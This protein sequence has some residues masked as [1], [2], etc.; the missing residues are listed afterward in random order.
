MSR[1]DRP[2]DGLRVKLVGD[3]SSVHGG[4][5]AVWR[6]IR[7]LTRQQGAT[8]V[9]EDAPYDVLIVNGEGS[10]HH[11]AP[12]YHRK[13]AVLADA[14]GRG[15]PA[16]LINT[17]WQDNPHD[18]DDVLQ[19]LEGVIVRESRSRDAIRAHGVEPVMRPDLSWFAPAR[20]PGRVRDFRGATVITD[21]YSP[22]FGH[23]ARPSAG[24]MSR[25]DYF[26]FPRFDWD[27]AIATLRTVRLLITGRQHAIYAC[28]RARTPFVAVKGNTHKIEG[29]IEMAGAD[30]P[31]LDRPGD[32]L[33][34]VEAM[35]ERRAEF[36]KLFD[37]LEAQSMDGAF[38]DLLSA[39]ALC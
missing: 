18:Q 24:R 23:F 28:C 4:C 38:P 33:E 37:W 3:H 30:I 11:G 35:L 19:V 16:W 12:S 25:M 29:L 10:M 9:G 27:G 39:R 22:D 32:A 2:A 15:K 20:A 13:M 1:S 5:V 6:Q 36:D 17:V 34:Q 21:F 31:V 14:V 26:D 7:R 8:I